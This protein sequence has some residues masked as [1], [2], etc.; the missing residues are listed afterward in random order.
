MIKQ[1]FSNPFTYI[2]GYVLGFVL[3]FGDAYHKTPSV[4]KGYFGGQEY[5][6]HNGPGTKAAG[7]LM[8]SVF[9]PLYWSVQ[10]QRVSTNGI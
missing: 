7:A 9:W 10:H 5:T 4:E 2:L 8:A 1:I 6:L 3:T